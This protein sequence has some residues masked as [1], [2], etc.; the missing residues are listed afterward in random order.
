MSR[1]ARRTI[2]LIGLYGISV[3]ASAFALLPLIW[4]VLTSFKKSDM[5]LAYPP[6]WIPSPGTIEN[7]WEVIFGSNIPR[8]FLNS[9]LT[10]G[11]TMVLSLAVGSL[12]GYAASR[13]RFPGKDWLMMVLL[14]T[15]MIPGIV[16]LV[17]VYLLVVKLGLLNTHM[18]LILAYSAW[19][20]PTVTWLM[21]GFFDSVPREM[22]ESALIDGCTP[23]SAF[24]RIAVPLMQPG[25]AAT[26]IIIFVWVWNEFLIGLT[27]TTSDNMR[28][29]PVGLYTY[30]SAFGIEWTRLMAAVCLALLP[31][32]VLFVL[33]QRRFIQGLTSGAVKN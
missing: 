1:N 19:Q 7:Y 17:P 32:V 29:V 13:F 30:V 16:T 5:A 4:A 22:E 9:G 18:A 10:V 20:V 2:R 14:I 23:L 26:A 28:L 6:R 31:V 11:G 12:A 33:L 21:R 24:Y 15:I 27:L 25:L 8:Y 3:G